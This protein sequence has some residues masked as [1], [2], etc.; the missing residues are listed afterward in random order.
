MFA[1]LARVATSIRKQAAE[2]IAAA[3][4]VI[5]ANGSAAVG[6]SLELTRTVPIAR[7]LRR[8]R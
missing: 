2:L 8:G 6:P 1:L 5:L 3:P 7:G 4:D